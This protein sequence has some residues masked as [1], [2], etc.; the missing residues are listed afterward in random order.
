MIGGL[1]NDT[2]TVDNIGDVVTEN[3]GAGT[4]TLL[5]GLASYASSGPTSKISRHVCKRATLTGNALNNVITGGAGAD[6]MTGG[7]GN[8]AYVVNNPGDAV[9]ENPV[10]VLIRS[11]HRSTSSL[12]RTWKIWC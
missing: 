2:Y 9:I 1:G 10:E 3:P 8:D 5:T 4:D 12:Q 6:A 7:A 11:I